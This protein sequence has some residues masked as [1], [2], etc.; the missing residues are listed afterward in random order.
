MSL[1]FFLLVPIGFSIDYFCW[2]KL[3]PC[4]VA[5]VGIYFILLCYEVFGN[6]LGFIDINGY[7]Y[8]YIL[9]FYLVG[10][11][12]S[13]SAASLNVLFYK[14]KLPVDKFSLFSYGTRSKRLILT[15]SLIMCVI[16][17][18]NIY[19]AYLQL[20]SFVSEDFEGALTY[21][22]AGHSFAVLMATLPFLTEIYLKEQRKKILLLIL[23]VF[24][25]LFM[26]Q[27]K[28]WV[29]IPLVW[30]VWY[31]I[32][33]KFIKLSIKKYFSITLKLAGSLFILF[34]LVYFM[35]VVMSNQT[36]TLDYSAVIFSILIHFFGYLFSGILTLS[37][38]ESM[39]MFSHIDSYDPL[40][41][42]AGF[43]NIFNAFTGGELISLELVRPM[44]SLNTIYPASGN[45][46]SLW[47][48]MLLALGNYSFI[49][50]FFLIFS[51]S[52]LC[53]LSQY[54]KIMLLIYTFLTSFMF[55]SWFDYYYYLL[56]P[57][58]ISVYII[59]LYSSV[60][61]LKRKVFFVEK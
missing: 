43:L 11:I 18:I 37:T 1:L 40:G 44:V 3:T 49:F 22:F 15:I 9:L 53:V 59:V 41:L 25:L 13:L 27:V 5:F 31:V 29:M 52:L 17:I 28:Y 58:E 57:Y 42:V 16:C 10:L 34:F 56:P 7:V 30:M 45:V 8:F 48:T 47:G 61:L 38:Y 23:L 4:I 21:G 32:S 54:S 14:V 2:K 19:L 36:G 51:L 55:F 24:C 60:R 26:K 6:S 50:F 46:P 39:G 33:G 35:K 12:A 20:G